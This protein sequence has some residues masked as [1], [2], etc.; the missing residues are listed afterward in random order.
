VRHSLLD[1]Y[2]QGT[3]LVHR[4]DPRLKLLATLAFVLA[5]T[6]TPPPAWP[7]FVLLAALALGAIRLA[8]IPLVEGLKRSAIALPFA[9]MVALSL[10]FTRAGQALWSWHLLGWDLTVTDEGVLLFAAVLIKSWLSVLVSGLL[11]ATTCWPDLLSALR[12][13]RAPAVLT[14]TISFM[15]R[16]LVV[17]VDEALRLQTARESRSAAPDHPRCRTIGRVRGGAARAGRTVA[18]QARVLG[19]MIGSL[20]IRSFERSERIYAAMLARGFAGEV[21]SLTRLT[22]RARDSWAGL[23]WGLALLGVALL[24]QAMA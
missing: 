7:A 11:V 23:V 15:V 24:G 1:R 12:S 9:G 21:R 22:W 17:L 6:S 16:Y 13:L 2:R 5:A 3:S 19:G 4:L 14:V 20:F 18:W 10:P 8:H